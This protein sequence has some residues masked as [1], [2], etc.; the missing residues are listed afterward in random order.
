MRIGEG[1]NRL[2][3]WWASRPVGGVWT[4]STERQGI[5]RCTITQKELK[6]SVTWPLGDCT[7]ISQWIHR[8]QHIVPVFRLSYSLL[9][10]D[11]ALVQQADKLERK[12]FPPWRHSTQW[13]RASFSSRLHDH[14]QTHQNRQDS[15]G[16]V[17]SQTQR[18]LPDKTQH[19]KD[20][21]IHSPSGI[22]IRNSSKRAA[23]DPQLRLRGHWDQLGTQISCNTVTQQLT[24]IILL[25][26]FRRVRKI[27]KSNC[28]L[29][30]VCP[31]V[32]QHRTPRLP[33]N[34]FP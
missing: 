24:V 30:H 17:I 33:M 4:D 13:A 14:T 16:L 26:V 20:T 19:S 7:A 10:D 23:V 28:Q 9:T 3:L 5:I 25:R 1:E 6:R 32:C 12:F 34:E 2:G 21:D 27:G 22:R 15:S 11:C 8:S 18:P 31:S 29:R